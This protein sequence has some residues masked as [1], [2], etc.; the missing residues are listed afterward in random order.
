MGFDASSEFEDTSTFFFAGFR[1]FAIFVFANDTV[2]TYAGTA[3]FFVAGFAAL[4][5]FIGDDA[6]FVFEEALLFIFAAIAVLAIDD[7]FGDALEGFGVEGTE[8][9]FLTG[10]LRLAIGVGDNGAF[11]TSEEAE[12]VVLALCGVSTVFFFGYDTSTV[13]GF[14]FTVVDTETTSSTVSRIGCYAFPITSVKGAKALTSA[15]LAFS[16][17]G[18]VLLLAGGGCNEPNKEQEGGD[19]K[20]CASRCER[21]A[22]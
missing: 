15:T 8:S 12:A 7:G 21:L 1:A 14:T 9:L 16:T 18:G 19:A 5:H 2:G 6:L 17:G 20:L 13:F 22:L 11:I 10:R 3:S 4:A